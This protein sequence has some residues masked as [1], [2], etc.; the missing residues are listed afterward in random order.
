MLVNL[1]LLAILSSVATAISAVQ[2]QSN[3]AFFNP[4]QGNGT[5]LDDAGNTLGE[6]LNVIIAGN[7]SPEVL[8]DAGIL[9]FSQAIGFSAEC[10]GVHLGAPQLANLGDG[11][12]PQPQLVELRA[13]YGNPLV[14]TCLEQLIGGS[15]F[16]VWRQNGTSANT[17]ALFLAV[18]SE[19]GL[20]QDHTIAADGYNRGRD[21][22]VAG[23]IGQ[24]SF[25]GTTYVTTA[26][27]LTGI[28]PAG[29][30]GVNHNI[31]IDGTAVLLTVMT[32]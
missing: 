3:T 6:P 19:L 20:L 11:N 9:Q 7:S 25:N 21:L 4:T 28:M 31:S 10:L 22:L 8:T 27:N 2:E 14:G 26:Q 24:K 17:G 30:I 23:A 32:V 18:S 29:S 16:R 15:H 13:D 1:F 5:F 12:G